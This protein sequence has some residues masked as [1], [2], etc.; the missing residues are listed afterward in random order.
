MMNFRDFSV[1]S[2]DLSL[3]GIVRHT[4]NLVVVLCLAALQG[5][6]RILHE[7]V[8]DIL[9]VWPGLAGLLESVDSRFEVFGIQLSLGLLEKTVERVL[10]QLE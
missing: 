1:G 6:L 4:Q 8:D 9:L 7:R 3:I 5:N 10:I 2:L